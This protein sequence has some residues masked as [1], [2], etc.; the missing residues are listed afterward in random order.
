M[1]VFALFRT[2]GLS[3]NSGSHAPFHSCSMTKPKFIKMP[4]SKNLA[5]GNSFKALAP[6][7]W[8]VS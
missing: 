2:F 8:R 5:S 7:E 4:E 3:V 6:A 1:A